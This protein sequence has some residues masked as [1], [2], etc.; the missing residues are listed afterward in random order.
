VVPPQHWVGKQANPHYSQFV[1]VP[2]PVIDRIQNQPVGGWPEYGVLNIDSLD[3]D[4]LLTNE[5][6]PL[7]ELASHLT[8]LGLEHL[9]SKGL[10]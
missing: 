8:A 5:T 2:V 10:L 9:Q 6:A 7:L 4:P 1:S 3:A